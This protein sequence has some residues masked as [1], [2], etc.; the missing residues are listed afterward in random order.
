MRSRTPFECTMGSRTPFR[1]TRWGRALRNG[2]RDPIV[3]SETEYPLASAIVSPLDSPFSLL[4]VT[5]RRCRF[6]FL[7]LRGPNPS[8][9]RGTARV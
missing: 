2:V 4:G 6:G 7:Q 8:P 1:S 3:H 5:L 9:C